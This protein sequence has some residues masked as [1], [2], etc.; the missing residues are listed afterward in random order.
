MLPIYA[1][2]L[3]AVIALAV[4]VTPRKNASVSVA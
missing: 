4:S 3:I 2:F 1:P